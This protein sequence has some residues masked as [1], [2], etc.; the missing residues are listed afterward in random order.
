MSEHGVREF[1]RMRISG[2]W[3]GFT[4]RRC[5]I[6]PIGPLVFVDCTFDCCAFTAVLYYLSC[7][8]CRFVRD[9]DP[10]PPSGR[11]DDY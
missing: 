3:K 11:S 6:E 10:P 9:T 4:F 8:D 5:L 7:Y 2:L 1:E